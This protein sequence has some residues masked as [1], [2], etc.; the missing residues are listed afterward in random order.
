MRT[1]S[2][3]IIRLLPGQVIKLWEAIKYG[4]IR[5][6][7]VKEKDRQVYLNELLHAL[8]NEKAQCFIRLSDDRRLFAILITRFQ[9]D[10]ITGNKDLYLQGLYSWEIVNN[11]IWQRDI[12]FIRDFARREKC[13]RITFKSNVPRVMEIAKLLEFKENLR[14][15]VFDL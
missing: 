10:K 14:E 13:N 2:T 4:V 8:L 9:V 5:A 6:D 11:E 7:E 1:N 15:F 3:I 12:D